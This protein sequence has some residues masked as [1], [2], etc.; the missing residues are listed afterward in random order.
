MFVPS[1]SSSF[2]R[3]TNWEEIGC[4]RQA[5]V[6]TLSRIELF[7]QNSYFIFQV[8]QVFLVT[9]ITSAA[10]AAFTQILENPME[11]REL[12]SE[13]LP[14]ASN[15][16]V[17]YFILQ[18]LAM[19]STRIVH[20][21][22]LFRVGLMAHSG[23]NP[24]M[25][26]KRYHRL[27]VIHWGA[28]YPVFTNMGVIGMFPSCSKAPIKQSKEAGDAPLALRGPLPWRQSFS[29][30]TNQLTS[31]SNILLSNRAHHRRFRLHRPPNN[32]HHLPLQP[33]LRL[34]LRNL[35]PRPPLP[36][37]PKTHP[38][39]RLP[40]R[41]LHDRSLRPQKRLRTP[42]PNH[43]SPNLHHPPPHVSQRLSLPSPLQPPSYPRY[44]GRTPSRRPRRIG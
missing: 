10:S 29:P 11:I 14:K 20:L 38:N 12:L 37:C 43:R 18:G 35:H 22:S 21:M 15:F 5:G 24:R 39:R 26:W 6:P 17:S 13:N 31:P 32:L 1:P 36:P 27:R 3:I 25:M 2:I 8:V 33:P 41:N 9:T 42:N 7:T 40:R 19:S 34:L 16:Y 4:A 28:V 44:R 30:F 23:K